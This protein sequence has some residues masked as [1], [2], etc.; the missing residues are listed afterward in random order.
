MYKSKLVKFGVIAL[1]LGC[2]A[3]GCGDKKED[4]QTKNAN[5]TDV[6]TEADKSAN[7]A[8]ETTGKTEPG[9]DFQQIIDDTL[10]DK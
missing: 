2:V 9:D 1:V 6:T 5:A 4:N 3:V 7:N 8:K 10:A